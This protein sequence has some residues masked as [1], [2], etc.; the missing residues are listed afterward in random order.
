MVKKS[1]L[2][3]YIWAILDR[4]H[5]I[6]YPE[7]LEKFQLSPN[8]FSL[9]VS[10]RL[11]KIIELAS[12]KEKVTLEEIA[13]DQQ[14]RTELFRMG[15]E[16]IRAQYIDLMSKRP[17]TLKY[18][19][20]GTLVHPENIE[21]LVYVALTHHHPELASPDRSEIVSG[22]NNLP[23]NLEVYLVSIGLGGLMTH[24][25]NKREIGSPLAVIK[26][27]DKV[28]QAKTGDV[29]LFDL[30]Q[31]EH[32]H[33]WGIGH[34]APSNYWKDSA[35][36][37]R[38]LYHTLIEHNP[39]LASRNRSKVISGIKN[40]PTNLQDYFYS[41]KLGGVMQ[42]AFELGEIYSPRAVLRIFDIV[43]QRETGN[44]SLF[45]QRHRNYLNFGPGNRLIR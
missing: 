3:N 42:H 6:S 29:S 20:M 11:D 21:L 32:L 34:K 27:F 39:Q 10:S 7:I 13:S 23:S 41:I 30:S 43:Y 9:A 33:E 18:L 40:L 37:E 14:R 35:N 1:P 5:G 38:A 12:A 28:Y 16:F 44:K 15:E 31:K 19:Y 24:A 22:M 25:F 2:E 45:D 8:Q 4:D 36:V 26:V 17:N